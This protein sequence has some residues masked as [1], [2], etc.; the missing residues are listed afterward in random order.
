[1]LWQ[2]SNAVD[3]CDRLSLQCAGGQ[4][5]GKALRGLATAIASGSD[6]EAELSVPERR[7][8]RVYDALTAL[9]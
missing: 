8:D 9:P 6:A 5:A 7:V 3:R 2:P 1:M 4:R